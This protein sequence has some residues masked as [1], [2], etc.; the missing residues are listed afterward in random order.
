MPGKVNPTQC[1][2][3]TMLCCQVMGNDVAIGIGGASGNFE[4]NVFKPLIA[5]NFLQSVRL[6]ADGMSSFE[7]HCAR[8]IEADRERIGELLERSL[9]LVTALAPHIGYDPSLTS[10][11]LKPK[12]STSCAKWPASVPTRCCSSPAARTRKS[13]CCA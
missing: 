11:G 8:G 10:T 7:A 1:E 6:L 3:L 5:H 2:A 9:M 12:P 13:A 4:L